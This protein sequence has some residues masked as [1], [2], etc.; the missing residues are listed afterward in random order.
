MSG[1]EDIIQKH[2]S[3]KR[4]GLGNVYAKEVRRTMAAMPECN[5]AKI[6]G[7]QRWD[8]HALEQWDG[9]SS[10]ERSPNLQSGAD[11]YSR[12]A[13]AAGGAVSETTARGRGSRDSILFWRICYH[14]GRWGLNLTSAEESIRKYCVSIGVTCLHILDEGK[15]SE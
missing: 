15:R 3:N 2:N 5:K 14:W 9:T 1:Q 12:Q 8:G 7:P 11:C 10:G 4:V 13:P 6:P